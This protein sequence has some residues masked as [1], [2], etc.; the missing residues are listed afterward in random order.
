M[1]VTWDRVAGGYAA[2][3]GDKKVAVLHTK[4]QMQ[5]PRSPENKEKL[6]KEQL[7]SFLEGG[8]IPEVAQPKESWALHFTS[9]S[10]NVETLKA[11]IES[12]PAEA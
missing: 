3:I 1:T 12:I 8:L 4:D 9:P 10:Q 6:T 5:N 2:F 11:I 7:G